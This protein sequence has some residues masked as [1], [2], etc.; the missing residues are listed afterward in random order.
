MLGTQQ[1]I[2]YASL[3]PASLQTLRLIESVTGRPMPA[4]VFPAIITGKALPQFPVA[5]YANQPLQDPLPTCTDPPLSEDCS[6]YNA[7]D[8]NGHFADEL[9][10]CGVWPVRYRWTAPAIGL[11]SELCGFRLTESG[12]VRPWRQAMYAVNTS[13][14]IAQDRKLHYPY[15]RPGTPILMAYGPIGAVTGDAPMYGFYFQH[16]MDPLHGTRDCPAVIDP[17]STCCCCEI[18]L[19][20][21]PPIY[22]CTTIFNCLQYEDSVAHP[23][24]YCAGVIG[25]PCLPDPPCWAG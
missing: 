19:S 1:A 4:T 11:D 3:D 23:I 9:L 2:N 6:T 8:A 13:H 20:S 16:M 5:P 24:E 7:P 12:E 14:V 18:P 10:P 15:V 21:G 22:G 17:G 25:E